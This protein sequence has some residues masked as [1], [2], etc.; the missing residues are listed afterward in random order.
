MRRRRRNGP[1]PT[2]RQCFETLYEARKQFY[3]VDVYLI[4]VTL[5]GRHD[6]GTRARAR[7]GRRHADQ[8]VGHGRAAANAGGPTADVVERAGGHRCGRGLCV[9][10]RVDGARAAALAA[11]NVL[12][13]SLAAGVRKYEALLGSS[14]ASLRSPA[15][16]SVACAAATAG[17]TRLSG[18]AA[19]HAWTTGVFP[20]GP[21]SKTRWEG[22]GFQHD[23]RPV[24]RAARRCQGRDLPGSVA[25]AWPIRWTT[26]T[27]RRC[28]LPIGRARSVPGT[29]MLRRIA[30]LSP[31]LGKFTLLGRLLSATPT[32]RAGCRSLGRTNTARRI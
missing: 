19:L 3:P 15:R 2:W 18:R 21:Q 11:G 16:G 1:R 22:F 31:V 7:I 4:D 24:A 25:Q 5:L 6:V 9:G 10:R 8:S 13:S 12:A 29:T 32:C 20:L 27:W 23:R 28:S 26:T 30:R 14:S 17:Q